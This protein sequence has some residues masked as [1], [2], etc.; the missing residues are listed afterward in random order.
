MKFFKVACLLI[1]PLCCLGHKVDIPEELMHSGYNGTAAVHAV[2]TVIES[3]QIFQ[4]Y[5][6]HRFLRRL[7]NVTS[8]D[9]TTYFNDDLMLAGGGIWGIDDNKLNAMRETAKNSTIGQELRV[10]D[11]RIDDY[12]G[13]KILEKKQVVALKPIYGGAAAYL[14]LYYLML[15]GHIDSVPLA[16]NKIGQA[17]LWVNH[18]CIQSARTPCCKEYFVA[19]VAILEEQE[20]IISN[21]ATIPIH[22]FHIYQ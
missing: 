17:D 8:N 20:G 1:A 22:G 4:N 12:L 10:V 13:V 11:K 2:L 9:G 21:T 3:T 6:H 18:F 14:Y 15:L 7:A 16:E 5:S 19:Q